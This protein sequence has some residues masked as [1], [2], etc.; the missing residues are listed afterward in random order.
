ME[1]WKSVLTPDPFGVTL[2]L[3]VA[4]LPVTP[5]AARVVAVVTT[6]VVKLSVAR[7]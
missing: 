4:A 1:Y 2:P 3:S 5:D 7:R 6:G